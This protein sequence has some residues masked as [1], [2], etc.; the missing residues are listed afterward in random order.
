MHT[1]SIPLGGASRNGGKIYGVKDSDA[2]T[3]EGGVI[4][5]ILGLI[6]AG[7]MFMVML[8]MN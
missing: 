2:Q 8:S 7:G 4:G 3:G 6:V 5:L 1:Q